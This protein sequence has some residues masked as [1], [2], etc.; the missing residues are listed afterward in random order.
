MTTPLDI[1]RMAMLDAGIGAMG[2]T[3]SDEEYQNA[4]LKLNWMIAELREE[5]YM[6][7]HLVELV[8]PTNGAASFTIGPGGD[9]ERDFAPTEL[10]AA[11]V[12]LLGTGVT[13]VDKPLV[14]LR[15]REDWARIS[16][17]SLSSFPVYIFMDTG[18]PLSTV[19]CW[20][21]P[22]ASVYAIHM[23]VLMEL[24]AFSNIT[25][26][27]ALPA[28]YESMLHANLAVRLTVNTGEL[29]IPPAMVA[30]A[31]YT[32]ALVRRRN[33]QIQRAVMPRGLPGVRRSGFNVLTGDT[34]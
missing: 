34:V 9:I 16:V 12:R 22:N 3:I 25:E 28:V 19:Y 14:I 15:A 4:F 1:I 24:P 23:D 8:W 6:L 7:Y 10:K 21:I 11:F 17:K 5:R 32:K 26:D 29:Q 2:E 13:P 31:K 33:A 20:P 18:Y 27:V 30:H